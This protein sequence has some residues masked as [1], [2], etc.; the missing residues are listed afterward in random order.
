MQWSVEKHPILNDIYNTKVKLDPVQMT[1]AAQE[2]T[3][4][5]VNAPK[6]PGDGQGSGEQGGGGLALTKAANIYKNMTKMMQPN[7]V[8]YECTTKISKG[9]C[10]CGYMQIGFSAALQ[11]PVGPGGFMPRDSLGERTMFISDAGTSLVDTFKP[12]NRMYVV[13]MQMTV[14]SAKEE[15]TSP[16]GDEKRLAEGIRAGGAKQTRKQQQL[17]SNRQ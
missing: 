3:A 10:H 1:N 12:S 8:N 16:K 2:A 15:K 9:F 13:P 6:K 7:T 17:R 14:T 5:P 4:K 11:L